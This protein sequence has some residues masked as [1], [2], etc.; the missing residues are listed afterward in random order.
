MDD[1]TARLVRTR[2]NNT[3]IVVVRRADGGMR[4]Y[5][6]GA[7]PPPGGPEVGSRIIVQKVDG[8]TTFYA[9]DGGVRVVADTDRPM[10]C[11]CPREAVDGGAEVTPGLH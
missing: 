1:E 6:P 2:T 9:A 11:P 3:E 8:G 7:W 10:F 5:P 4:T